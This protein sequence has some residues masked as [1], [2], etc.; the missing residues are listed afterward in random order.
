[1]TPRAFFSTGLRLLGVWKL[2]EASDNLVTAYNISIGASR[3][4]LMSLPSYVNHGTVGAVLGLLLLFG[5]PFVA[6]LLVPPSTSTDPRPQN[7][8]EHD[9]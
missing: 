9:A 6:A 5:A 4:D 2:L 1:M 8:Q 3:T 7:S